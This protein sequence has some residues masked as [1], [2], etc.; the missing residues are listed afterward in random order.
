[1]ILFST[2]RHG[3]WRVSQPLWGQGF[4]FSK[5]GNGRS[6]GLPASETSPGKCPWRQLP[7]AW[8]LAPTLLKMFC[9]KAAD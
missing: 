6:I 2:Y 7:H 9:E 1:M 3:H 4:S 5:D 8:A